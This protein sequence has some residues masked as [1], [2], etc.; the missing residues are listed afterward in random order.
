VRIVRLALPEDVPAIVRMAVRFLNES[1]YA[2]QITPDPARIERFVEDLLTTGLLLIAEQDDQPIG[3]LAAILFEHPFS[4]ART[5]SEIGWWVEPEYRGGLTGPQMLRR[6]E[7][8][9]HQ[10]HAQ[11][12]LMI[13][14]AGSTVGRLYQRRGYDELETTF[15]LQLG[16]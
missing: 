10:Q 4:G 1:T 7:Q 6:A 14:P 2:D 8:W 15:Q 9:A 12:M 13:A 11:S 5:V 3:M 16:S